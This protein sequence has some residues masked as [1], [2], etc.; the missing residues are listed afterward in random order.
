QERLAVE[1]HHRVPAQLLQPVVGVDDP[2]GA[3]LGAH[4][5]GLGVGAAGAVAYPSQ[6]V[7]GGD[8][9]GYEEAVVPL[10]QLVGGQHAVQVVAGRPGLLP[11]GVIARP[12]PGVQRPTHAL[13]RAGGHDPLRRAADA[14]QHV[15]VGLLPGG[16]D[17]AGDVAVGDELD[18]GA[19]LA[20]LLHEFGVARAVQ[21]AYRDLGDRGALHPGDP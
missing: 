13:E 18:P 5:D 12:E 21:D 7:T 15:H 17:R 4:H 8:P 10:D 20:Y 14:H 3:A 2:D 19:G 11:L 1:V 6:Q 16:A 9:G